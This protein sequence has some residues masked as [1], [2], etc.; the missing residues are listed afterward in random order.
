[1]Q[2]QAG[3][4]TVNQGTGWGVTVRSNDRP[5]GR[6]QLQLAAAA[7]LRQA[8]G[9]EG[10]CAAKA[11]RVNLALTGRGVTV[12]RRCCDRRFPTGSSIRRITGHEWVCLAALEP[13]RVDSSGDPTAV[14]S[15]SSELQLPTRS[16]R[17]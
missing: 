2:R 4:V 6:C 12:A 15:E 5:R 11:T 8:H 3:G 16:T 7:L 17:L 13:S 14:S 1:M 9:L 10:L